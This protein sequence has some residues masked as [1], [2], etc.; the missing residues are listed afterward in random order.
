M[1]RTVII[2]R[3]HS[4]NS[5]TEEFGNGRWNSKK[6]TQHEGLTVQVWLMD[7]VLVWVIIVATVILKGSLRL[8]PRDAPSSP[9]FQH[10]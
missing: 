1:Q 3:S 5:I 9:D 2:K 4:T 8:L 6:S 10:Y 7:G